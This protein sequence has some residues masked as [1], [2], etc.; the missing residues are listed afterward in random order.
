MPQVNALVALQYDIQQLGAD[1]ALQKRVNLVERQVETIDRMFDISRISHVTTFIVEQD[2]AIGYPAAARKIATAAVERSISLFFTLPVSNPSSD[3]IDIY[4]G[5]DLQHRLADA[6]QA[7]AHLDRFADHVEATVPQFD[8]GL[9][10]G[11]AGRVLAAWGER[12]AATAMFERTR[13]FARRQSTEARD[14]AYPRFM[15]LIHVVQRAAEAGYFDLSRD[16]LQ[17]ADILRESAH[18]TDLKLQDTIAKLMKYIND[19]EAG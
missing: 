16:V 14:V 19:R 13:A 15:I 12:G 3:A 10:L 9:I 8:G 7:R 6:A 17:E 1:A 11:E 5:L 4:K 18:S 2:A